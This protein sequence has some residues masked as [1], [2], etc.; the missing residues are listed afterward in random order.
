MREPTRSGRD[1]SAADVDGAAERG[2]HHESVGER[3]GRQPA[4]S[5]SSA[6]KVG[7]TRRWNMLRSQL[8]HQGLWL[9]LLR[10]WRFHGR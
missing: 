9:W 10:R 2:G 7:R 5:T 4:P 6:A 8:R 1:T 3:Q